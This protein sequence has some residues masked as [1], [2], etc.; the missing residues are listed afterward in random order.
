MKL[1]VIGKSSLQ[2][3]V[4]VESKARVKMM[5]SKNF[6]KNFLQKFV[7]FNIMLALFRLLLYTQS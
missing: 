6:Y 4:T 3:V 2:P 7:F 5:L 1:R